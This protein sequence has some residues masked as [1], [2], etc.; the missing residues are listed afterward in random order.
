MALFM[1]CRSASLPISPPHNQVHEPSRRTQNKGKVAAVCQ[2][3]SLSSAAGLPSFTRL[4]HCNGWQLWSSKFICT[5]HIS[6]TLKANVQL[7]H[8]CLVYITSDNHV[9]PWHP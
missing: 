4:E 2:L 1:A 7:R 5:L 8:S 9:V 6:V 3:Y